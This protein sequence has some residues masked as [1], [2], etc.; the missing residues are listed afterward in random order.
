MSFHV[1]L[2]ESLYVSLHVYLYVS[3]PVSLHL[4]L[5]VS[6]VSSCLLMSPHVSFYLSMC[7]CICMR[8]CWGLGGW[9]RG[10]GGY[11]AWGLGG[12]GA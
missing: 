12:G 10:V 2:N 4:S 8:G 9:M 1:S 7:P 5:N 3:L 11:R 6:F